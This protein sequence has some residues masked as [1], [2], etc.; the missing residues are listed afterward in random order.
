M[1]RKEKLEQEVKKQRSVS[2]ELAFLRGVEWADE[3]PA[4]ISVEERLPEH[5]QT[6]LALADWGEILI[7]SYD[8][9]LNAFVNH[10]GGRLTT[11]VTHWMPLPNKPKKG[12][13]Q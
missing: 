2:E 6:V 9:E 10:N 8:A 1:N 5:S 12:G 7:G 4:W 13:E 3:N 11:N